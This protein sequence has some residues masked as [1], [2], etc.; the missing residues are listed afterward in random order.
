MSCVFIPRIWAKS[1]AD[2]ARRSTLSARC[3]SSGARNEKCAVL[4]RWSTKR[5]AKKADFAPTRK[6]AIAIP[7]R[8]AIATVILTL[9]PI[10]TAEVIDAH[11]PA[12]ATVRAAATV[13]VANDGALTADTDFSAFQHGV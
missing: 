10:A 9:I 8:T 4:S 7:T 3:C 11:A 2:K 12:T 5:T 1:S 6:A 13:V